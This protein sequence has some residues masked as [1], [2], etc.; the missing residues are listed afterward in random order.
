MKAIHEK[1]KKLLALSKSANQHE[2]AAAAARAA[3]LMLKHQIAEADITVEAEED[4]IV[5]GF[6]FE[7]KRRVGWKGVLT[8]GLA[9]SLGCEAIVSRDGYSVQYRIVGTANAVSA[10]QYMAPSIINQINELADKSWKNASSSQSARAWKGSFRMA[11]ARTVYFRL[12]D[13]RETV[14]AD[15]KEAGQE[16]ALIVLDR[17]AIALK[18]YLTDL[19]VGAA[20]RST[21]GEGSMGGYLAGREAGKSV[22]LGNSAGELTPGSKRLGS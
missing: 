3:E 5:N 6:L 8:L 17:Q 20:R 21:A 1:I 10:I 14:L 19:N 7:T 18:S 11:A 4:P 13:A 12:Q 2:A 9:R 15:A 16:N 22:S